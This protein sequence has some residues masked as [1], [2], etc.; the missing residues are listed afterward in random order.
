MCSPAA[1][2]PLPL[3]TP[4]SPPTTPP[5][6][7]RINFAGAAE[8][9][10][11][12]HT[13]PTTGTFIRAIISPAREQSVELLPGQVDTVPGH[14]ETRWRTGRL[15]VVSRIRQFVRQQFVTHQVDDEI[16]G[17][18][19]RGVFLHL[20]DPVSADAPRIRSVLTLPGDTTSTASS[21]SAGSTK[22]ESSARTALGTTTTSGARCVAAGPR[23]IGTSTSINGTSA[24]GS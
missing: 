6:S 13:R 22:G 11:S 12:R 3:P 23:R 9:V 20:Q 5:L 10:D 17:N 18:T 24:L 1:C 14:G 8:L 16:R 2:P 21:T 19:D 4:S 7:A 15:G